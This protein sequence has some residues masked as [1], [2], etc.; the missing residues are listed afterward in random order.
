MGTKGH[1][2]RP[3]D[4]AAWSLGYDAAFGDILSD[5]EGSVSQETES[6][7]DDDSLSL[8]GSQAGEV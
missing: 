5:D 1:W 4:P 6:S 8:D 7:V 3:Y 2:R